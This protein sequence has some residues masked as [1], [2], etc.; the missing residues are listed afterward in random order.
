MKR[1]LLEAA[2]HTG[3]ARDAFLTDACRS[4]LN[5]RN[6][7][8]RIL[9]DHNTMTS[10]LES[11]VIAQAG[12][13]LS[14]MRTPERVG[15][16]KV[17]RLIAGGGMG[18]VF[19]AE[20]QNPQR[21]VALKVI[22]SELRTPSAQRR[23]EYE[24]QIVAQLRHPCIAQVYEAGTYESDGDRI[25]FFAMEF[26][27][28]AR[29]ITVYAAEESLTTDE[30]LGLFLQVCDAV[31]HAHQRGVIHR[32]LKPN[33]ILVDTAGRVY[34]IDFGVARAT[35]VDNSATLQTQAGQLMGTL[36]YMSPEQVG[37]D[38]DDVDT[39]TDIYA[40]GV[41]LFQLLTGDM[42]Y[43]V[44]DKTVFAAS[45]IIR[46]QAPARLGSFDRHWRGD[47]E[48]IVQTALRKDRDTRYQTVTALRQDVWNFIHNAP[49]SARPPS[50][51]YQLKMFALRHRGFVAGLTLAVLSLAIGSIGVTNLYIQARTARLAESK[52]RVTAERESENARR[53]ARI[54]AEVNRFLNKDLLASVSPD[55]TPNPD[56]TMREVLDAA[57]QRIEGRF[58]DAP[59]VEAS[60]RFTLG[61]TYSKLASYDEAATHLE[62]SVALLRESGPDDGALHEAVAALGELMYRV[63]D[64]E[65]ADTFL[66][67]AL[68]ISRRAWGEQDIRTALSMNSVAFLRLRQGRIDEAQPLMERSIE[69]GRLTHSEDDSEFVGMMMNLATLYLAR[70][71]FSE[72]EEILKSAYE[73]AK[74]RLGPLHPST[75]SCANT[76]ASVYND[77][78]RF[79]RGIALL[80]SVA[81]SQSQVLGADHPQTL[82]SLNN[83]G[84]ALIQS[85]RLDEAEPVVERVYGDR[86][87]LLG[88]THPHTLAAMANLGSLRRSQ[89]RY[90]EAEEIYLRNLE[91]H[92]ETL[93]DDHPDT[94]YCLGDL[95]RLYVAEEDYAAAEPIVREIIERRLRST[96][97]PDVVLARVYGMHAR[98]LIEMERFDQAE[99]ALLKAEGM[100]EQI[101]G[102][103]DP[104]TQSVIQR[105]VELYT[106]WNRQ[107]PRMAWEQRLK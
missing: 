13:L 92:R 45:H 50:L 47:V 70:E 29:S 1:I 40:L 25:P 95:V 38:P 5:L 62:R 30:R 16:Y 64:Y 77:L 94:I 11:P 87:R 67:E 81:D 56:V 12:A 83:L 105:L 42:P 102:L 43:D 34:V 100:L 99:A 9:D 22:R 71:Q 14:S 78:G 59:L 69:I 89:R 63:A 65:A 66:A 76:L 72:A 8:E 27:P 107:E 46:E 51:G 57:A 93:G 80:R 10:F 98:C 85:G 75:M 3:S 90:E 88:E 48:T 23:F 18:Q 52:L 36:Q 106:L 53:E 54:S 74:E 97:S 37:A 104:Q 49:I 58:V 41:I 84:F 17:R 2:E 24:A 15:A 6:E 96:P 79:D 32:D 82:V 86:M 19:E 28:D 26:V 20:Q 68:E 31:E 55:N 35:D 44:R 101:G 7:I 60:V 4:D 73:T 39:R 103:D 21:L 33:N 61:S 91:L